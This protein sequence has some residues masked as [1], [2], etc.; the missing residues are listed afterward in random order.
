MLH[1]AVA[2]PS[3]ALETKSPTG[4]QPRSRVSSQKTRRVHAPNPTPASIGP[5]IEIE[6]TTKTLECPRCKVSKWLQMASN[7]GE[8]A[9]SRGRKTEQSKV[10]PH[11]K[12]EC[13]LLPTVSFVFPPPSELLLVIFS[14][15]DARPCYIFPIFPNFSRFVLVLRLS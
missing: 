6:I 8:R 15:V 11:R 1:L 9:N 13:L 3:A 10:A 7:A 5:L 2:T 4:W 12:M 14:D